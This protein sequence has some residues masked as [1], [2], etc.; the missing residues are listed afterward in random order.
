MERLL[1]VL[2][3]ILFTSCSFDN[4]TG[5]WKDATNTSVENQSSKSILKKNQSSRYE[6]FITKNKTF[7][8]VKKSKISFNSGVNDPIKIK[9]W[10]IFLLKN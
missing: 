3:T 2:I 1:L 7:N 4:K 5:I 8:E 10:L 6:D 9:N